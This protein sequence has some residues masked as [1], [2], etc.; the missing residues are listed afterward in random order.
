MRQTIIAG[1]WKLHGTQAFA[2]A[3][4]SDLVKAL[5]LA[6][7]DVVILPPSLYVSGLIKT[8]A[9]S[10]IRF[11][12][13][14]ISAHASGAYTG[15]IAATMCADI[16]AL[17]T[18]VGHS[19]RRQYHH[20]SNVEVANKCSAALNAGIR[21]IVCVGESLQEREDG[22]TEEVIAAQLAPI[23]QQTKPAQLAQLIIAYEPVW[24]IGTGKT[25]SPQQAQDV[26]AFIRREFSRA[27]AMMAEQ[28][29]I[30]YGG[31]VKPDNAADLFAQKDI[32]GGL[33]GGA[34]LQAHDFL[35]IGRAAAHPDAR[36]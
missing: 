12:V 31:S 27:D 33:I 24:A 6:G 4:I 25:A 7:V 13:Q 19:E 3:L 29:S 11:G 1:N 5:P 23:L 15:E 34:S 2:D 9:Q 14:D 20:E 21:P 17:F 18:L 26:H 8:Y 36:I 16:G 10:G 22:K 30:L 28:L 35:A 32:D